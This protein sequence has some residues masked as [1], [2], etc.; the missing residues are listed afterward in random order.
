MVP[1]PLFTASNAAKFTEHGWS[2]AGVFFCAGLSDEEEESD[3][4]EKRD[5]EGDSLHS[6]RLR[7]RA[8]GLLALPLSCRRLQLSSRR[9]LLHLKL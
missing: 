4:K 8:G 2:F 5:E 9:H 7:M 6:G 1:L 3:E